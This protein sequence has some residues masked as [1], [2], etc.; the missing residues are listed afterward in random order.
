[1][2]CVGSATPYALSCVTKLRRACMCGPQGWNGFAYVYD[3]EG[4]ICGTKATPEHVSGR[5]GLRG[6][7]EE[8]LGASKDSTVGSG[9]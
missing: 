5:G 6:R 9:Y 2:H 3:G 8:G 7:R 1:M 4:K